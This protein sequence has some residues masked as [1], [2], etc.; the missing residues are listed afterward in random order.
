MFGIA[1]EHPETLWNR[2]MTSLKKTGLIPTKYRPHFKR[3]PS[4][5]HTKKSVCECLEGVSDANI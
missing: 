1:T 4:P 5:F 3:L 2:K